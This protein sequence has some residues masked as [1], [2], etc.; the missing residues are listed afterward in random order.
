V[1]VGRRTAGSVAHPLLQLLE[2]GG[3]SRATTAPGDC[4]SGA[5]TADK[6]KRADE[7]DQDQRLIKRLVR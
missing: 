1:L 2:F 4:A 7:P 6:T 5:W 3:C